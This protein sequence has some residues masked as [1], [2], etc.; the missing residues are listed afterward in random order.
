MLIGVNFHYV[1]PSFDQ[2]YPSFFGVTPEQFAARLDLLA[3]VGEFVGAREIRAALHGGRPLPERAWVVT[4][5]DGLREQY[6]YAWPILRA[7]GIP[8]IFFVNTDPIANHRVASVHKLH[9]LR[10]HVSPE[11]VLQALQAHAD[12]LGVR[13]PAIDPERAERQYKYDTPRAAQLKYLINIQLG[14]AERE[15]LVESCFG[16]LLSWSEEDLAR[17]LYMEPAHV[18]ELAAQ[19][20]I[21]THG[22]QHLPLGTLSPAEIT[23]QVRESLRLLAD[24]TP[25]RISA[26]SYPYGAPE[27]CAAPAGT[28]AAQEGLEF[29]FTMERAGNAALVP[30]MYLARCDNNDLPGGKAAR[31]S[32]DHVF[33]EIPHAAWERPVPAWAAAR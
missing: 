8:A 5:D 23:H 3:Q 25:E 24:W 16:E 12:E 31:W 2:P 4:F 33:D 18:A 11:R 15:R 29:A 13:L 6:E 19:G 26:L 27:A 1:R 30:P 14:A 32:L 22:H 9:Q 10:A 20:C 7:R 21:G 28:L 17:E